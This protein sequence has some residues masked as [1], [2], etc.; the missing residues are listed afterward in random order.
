[1]VLDRKALVPG[2]GLL[3]GALWI[4]ETVPRLVHAADVTDVLVQQGYWA[5]YN[6]PYFSD[7]YKVSGFEAQ[8]KKHG[9]E[10]SWSECARAKIFARDAPN[11]VHWEG[12]KALMRA[13]NYASDPL[14]D[15]RPSR[16][17]AARY[18]LFKE[19]SNSWFPMGAID[20][21]VSNMSSA[22]AL[23]SDIQ[24]GPTHETLPPFRWIND[25]N[26]N[27]M[28]HVGQPEVFDFP[29]ASFGPDVPL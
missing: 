18:D 15:G 12:M 29:W 17:V 24:Q 27:A 28:L 21:K 9:K 6:V 3:S 2:T 23:W 8:Y 4:I 16:Q 1:M 25:T 20:C 11:V 10:F 22:A 19:A 7:I 5:S 14:S 13:N 26:Y